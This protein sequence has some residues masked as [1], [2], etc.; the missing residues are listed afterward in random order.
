[1]PCVETNRIRHGH[2]AFRQNILVQIASA[3]ILRGAAMKDNRYWVV[4]SNVRSDNMHAKWRATI[5]DQHVA[6]MGWKPVAS[7]QTPGEFMGTSFAKEIAPDD[8]VLITHGNDRQ[9]VA[10]GRAAKSAGVPP[11][12]PTEVSA[13]YWKK[14]KGRGYSSYKRFDRFVPLDSDPARYGLS[15]TGTTGFGGTVTWAL[16]EFKPKQNPADAL[17]CRWIDSTLG[18]GSAK[19]PHKG[20]TIR[21]RNAKPIASSTTL[22]TVPIDHSNTEDYLVLTKS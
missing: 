9:L 12:L 16:Y 5:L 14:E 8:A 17:I 11:K 7:P 19:T 15:F 6:F 18:P 10:V 21:A 3:K 20:K 22:R 1:V 2:S 4:S 13:H